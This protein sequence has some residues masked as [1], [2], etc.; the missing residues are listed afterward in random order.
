MPGESYRRRL[1]SL[2]LYLC[3]VFRALINS[4][5]SVLSVSSFAT[6][7]CH[8]KEGTTL[9]PWI[10]S[11]KTS[12]PTFYSFVCVAFLAMSTFSRPIGSQSS[13]GLMVWESACVRACVHVH[14]M[15]LMHYVGITTYQSIKYYAS[16]IQKHTRILKPFQ[17]GQRTDGAKSGYCRFCCC[18]CFF[19]SSRFS[20]FSFWGAEC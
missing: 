1:R 11:N 4:L 16:T 2:L 5:V 3:C 14:G 20:P 19:F 13:N 9:K 6:V 8:L 17:W 10:R 18:C 12:I 7:C 15:N